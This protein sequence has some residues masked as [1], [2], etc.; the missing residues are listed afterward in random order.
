[1]R[2]PTRPF[3]FLVAAVLALLGGCA[4][5]ESAAVTA[6]KNR[7]LLLGNSQEPSDLD[8]QIVTA[9]TEM[10][11]ML[12][13]FEGLTALDE[14]TGQPV[15]SAAE[16]WE[17]S[18]DGLTYTFHLRPAAR[19]SNGDPLTAADFAWSFQRILTPALASEY[20]YMLWPIKNA[21]AFNEG[22]VTDFAQVG[23]RATGER[24]LVLT[25][26]APCPWLLSLAAHQ[27][28]FPVHR[29]TLEKFG[30]ATQKGT[31]WTRPEN[32]VGNG[33]FILKEW[34]PNA[35]IVTEANPRYW[36]AARN[37]LAGVT[38]F[39]IENGTTEENS[40]RAGQLHLTYGLPPDKIPAYREQS[41][42]RLR[43]DPFLETFFLTFNTTR[44]PFDNAKVRQ[45]LSLAID[46]T[47]LARD[48]LRGSVMP[49]AE[50][51]PPDTAGYTAAPAL[52]TDLA[53]A[54]RL[55]AEA[56][57]PGGRGLPAIELQVKADDVHR[58]SAETIQQMWQR[59]LGVTVT[60]APMEQKSWLAR[61]SAKDFQVST[62][63]WVGDYVDANTFLDMWVTG[64]GNN[65][66]GWGYPAYDALVAEAGRTL[67]APKRHDLQRRAEAILLEQ[68]PIIPVYHGTR[69]FLIDPAVQGWVPNLLGLHR[70][71]FIEL[72]P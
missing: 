26:D 56:G 32:L 69:V 38:F 35:R 57:F 25:L 28:W 67:D 39:P 15:P 10:N 24:T 55:L 22:K 1:M 20:S 58:I 8:P 41:P 44:A 54:R 11:L 50:F 63:R 46:R 70:Y 4:R 5:Q 60:L 65:W 3:V 18:P 37:K 2:T 43:V 31:R 19:W 34:T 48:A 71:Q 33:P 45:A 23:V 68:L 49:A 30:G 42:E 66:S 52:K 29:A 40:F 16:R 6:A 14:H 36:D 61:L 72:K 47:A 53:A 62:T 13:L 21:R 12:A 17:I 59:D 64:G 27:A 51:T 7:V 9:Y